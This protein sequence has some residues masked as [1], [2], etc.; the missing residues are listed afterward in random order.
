MIIVEQ[1][2]LPTHNLIKKNDFNLFEKKLFREALTSNNI[3]FGVMSGSYFQL[4]NQRLVYFLK[5]KMNI[6]Y[7]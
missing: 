5:L 4:T 6:F 3:P 2:S 1:A 7:S